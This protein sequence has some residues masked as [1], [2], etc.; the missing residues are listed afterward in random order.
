MDTPLQ[1]EVG[2]PIPIY[3]VLY[4]EVDGKRV[5]FTRCDALPF[6][7]SFS[8]DIFVHGSF[9]ATDLPD[10]ACGFITVTGKEP[11]TSQVTIKHGDLSASV[12]V[13]SYS[14]LVPLSPSNG[15]TLLAVGTSRLVVFTGGPRSWTLKPSEHIHSLHNP[16]SDGEIIDVIEQHARGQSSQKNVYAYQ[17]ACRQ[18]S[19]TVLTLQV[20]NKV[21][22]SSSKP[23][24]ATASITVICGKPKYLTLAPLL[25]NLARCPL[26]SEEVVALADRDLEVEVVV[27]D[28]QG[29]RFDNF[30]SLEMTWEVP[31]TILRHR[32]KNVKAVTVEQDGFTFPSTHSQRLTPSGSTDIVE[33]RAR[34]TGYDQ[35]TLFTQNISPE[36]PPFPERSATGKWETPDIHALLTVRFVTA[37]E[38]SPNATDIFAGREDVR[39]VRVTSGSGHF[40]VSANVS[41]VVD[42]E[43]D[44]SALRLKASV[45]G[46]VLLTVKDVCL[47]T[48]PAFL[49]VQVCIRSETT[50]SSAVACVL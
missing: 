35:E 39:E 47:D 7:V 13:A 24:T 1:A 49:T 8:E 42:V 18:L 50:K 2:V 37:I 46:N 20:V 6:V 45:V 34:I 10:S 15:V 25:K 29:R 44:R 40:E 38:V 36:N 3:I 19:E 28:A 23:A 30:T 17:I 43:R 22:S 33:V 11:G 21:V 5:P 26:H 48:K 9:S 16:N 27:K 14:P 4:G 41:G 31:K 12:V 32:Y